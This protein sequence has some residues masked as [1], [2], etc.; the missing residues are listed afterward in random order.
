MTDKLQKPTRGKQHDGFLSVE[1]K[2]DE[3]KRNH[4]NANQ[5]RHLAAHRAMLAAVIS[6]MLVEIKC[7]HISIF[8]GIFAIVHYYQAMK[9]PPGLA[10]LLN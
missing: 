4:W 6:K 9:A 2:H 5:M 3:G 10:F 1:E 8:A 7:A